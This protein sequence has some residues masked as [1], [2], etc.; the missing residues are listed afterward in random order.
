MAAFGD[1]AASEV[2]TSQV[3]SFLRSL[4]REGLKPRNVNKH[5]QVLA[6]MF[7][8]GCRSDT[9]VLTS[10]PV[11]GTDKRREDPPPALDYYEV[12]EVEALARAAANEVSIA[13]RGRLRTPSNRTPADARTV[14]TP[15]PSECC[16]T[17]A[18]VS[19]RC[20]RSAGRTSIS[21]TD[22]CWSAA[23]CRP[24]RRRCRKGDG[25]GSCPSRRPQR[26]HW[27]DSLTART[28]SL[29]MIMR[30]PIAGVVAS[31]RQHHDA[32]ISAGVPRRGFA[33]YGCTDRCR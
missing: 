23:A 17:P 15:T 1:R 6:A 22:C 32:A 31:I 26:P 10:N 30:W 28:F 4:D 21:K 33:Q 2:T 24:A 13:Q 27:L 11:R 14:A 5:R 9:F 20:S 18:C 25:L 8:Y 16:S 7:T 3:T 12:E 29:L 19:A